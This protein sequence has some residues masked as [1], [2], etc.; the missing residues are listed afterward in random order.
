MAY[1][2]KITGSKIEIRV[3]DALKACL[4]KV[5]FA[6]VGGRIEKTSGYG[7]FLVRLKTS[8]G[9]K[10]IIVKVKGSGQPRVVREAV[11]ELVRA[12][13]KMPSAYG[14]VAAPYISPVSAEICYEEGAG[15]VDF[16][17][18]CR[19][20]FDG[21][22]IEQTGKPNQSIAR[23]EQRSLFSQKSERILRVLLSSPGKKW[24]MANLAKEAGVSL[25]QV[26]NVK[27]LLVDREWISVDD[28]GM[29]LA[30][31][32]TILKEWEAAYSHRK[33][34]ALEFFTLAGIAEFEVMLARYCAAKNI[35]CALTGFSAANRY[36]PSVRSNRAMAYVSGDV[37]EISA[38]LG[39]KKVTS[40]ANV[41]LII[42]FDDGVYYGAENWDGVRIVSPLQTFLDL[43]R[44]RG[45]GE[46]AAQVILERKVRPAW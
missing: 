27:K 44:I 19:L 30:R 16:A 35:P 18:N 17:G 3:L 45:R 14:V 25:G 22:Y 1:I 20:C 26:F 2:M 34:Q 36:A 13:R 28:E 29:A 31:P 7:D 38:R 4:S 11:L 33:D 46:E 10:K 5:P 8:A 42:P 15:F 23:R 9:S 39:L 24:R 41:I 40:G 43:T 32:E 12:C 21:I 6:A 37:E